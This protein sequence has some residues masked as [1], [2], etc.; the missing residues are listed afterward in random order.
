MKWNS[1]ALYVLLVVQLTGLV[2]LYAWHESGRSQPTVMLRTQ[3]VDPRD[4]L[5]GDY[6]I[7][8]YDISTLPAEFGKTDRDGAEVFVVLKR[9]GEFAVMDRVMD[10]P[11][12]AGELFNR[13]RVRGQRIEYDLEK[14]FVPEGRGNPPQPITVEVAIRGDGR[15][16][17]KRIFSQGN[18]WPSG[19]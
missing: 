7:L 1:K 19:E 16:Q 13:R 15:A 9:D 6:I 12:E 2:G 5:R 8:N 11:P 17:I 18:P 14:F 4:L 10:W 3:P